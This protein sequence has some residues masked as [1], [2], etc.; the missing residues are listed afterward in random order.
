MQRFFAEP[1]QIDEAAHQIHITG[2]DVNHIVH[3]LRMKPGD[4][5]WISDGEKKEY[6]CRIETADEDEVCL[7]ILYA[8]EPDYELPGRI[9]LF[10]GNWELLRSFR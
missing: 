2:T 8:Q 10:Q 6:H 7:H 3:V 4:E 5:L 1:H 9:Y